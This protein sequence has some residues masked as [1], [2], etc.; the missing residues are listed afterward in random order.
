MDAG[1]EGGQGSGHPLAHYLADADL[2]DAHINTQSRIPNFH[3]PFHRSRPCPFHIVPCAAAVC[4]TFRKIEIRQIGTPL[5]E[6]VA[7]FA[8]TPF[9][10]SNANLPKQGEL[11]LQGHNSTITHVNLQHLDTGVRPMCA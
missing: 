3:Q 7:N 1:W 11:R 2:A 6:E 4:N 10:W 5:W 8:C 9:F